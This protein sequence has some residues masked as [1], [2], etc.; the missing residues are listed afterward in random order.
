MAKE[1]KTKKNPHRMQAIAWRDGYEKEIVVKCLNKGSVLRHQPKEIQGNAGK[2][3]LWA[4]QKIRDLADTGKLDDGQTDLFGKPEEVR[5]L[6]QKIQRLEA[7]LYFCQTS[8]KS[9]QVKIRLAPGNALGIINDCLTSVV[10]N[11]P[12]FMN[13]PVDDVKTSEE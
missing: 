5:Q 7:A 9:A 4:A 10:A 12:T 3:V 2:Q 6:E 1:V 13:E 8:V 11:S